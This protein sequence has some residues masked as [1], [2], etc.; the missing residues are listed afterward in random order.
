MIQSACADRA[1][2]RYIL[3]LGSRQ[4]VTQWEGAIHSA[5][6][7]YREMISIR[8]SRGLKYLSNFGL[9]IVCVSSSI[10]ASDINITCESS[11]NRTTFEDVLF[12]MRD[13]L[14]MTFASIT[15]RIYSSF[16]NSFNFSC[17]IPCFSACKALNSI[18]S[19]READVV[20]RSSN[21]L[22]RASLFSLLILSNLSANSSLT[23]KVIVL[24]TQILCLQIYKNPLTP[25]LPSDRP[26]SIL[27][28]TK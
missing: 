14:I 1:S 5:L 20:M 27:L 22:R 24:I 19:L 15:T 3:S 4:I 25:Y 6:L 21:I 8:V 2:S 16:S 7:K 18:R 9:R 10:V 23:L 11:I 12:T 26:S 28:A 17:V 13:E